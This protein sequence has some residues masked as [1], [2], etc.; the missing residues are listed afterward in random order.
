[1]NLLF[2]IKTILILALADNKNTVARTVKVNGVQFCLDF[3]DFHCMDKNVEEKNH[4][5]LDQLE[6]GV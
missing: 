2:L 6:C 3:T 5:D 1:M 4:A